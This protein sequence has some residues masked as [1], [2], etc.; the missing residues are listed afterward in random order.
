MSFNKWLR[1]SVLV[2]LLLGFGVAALAQ[3][4]TILG[5]VT[6]PTGAT[7]PNASIA[8]TNVDTG[9]V[10]QI[11][12]NEAGQFVAPGL[13]IGH[14]IVRTEVSGFKPMEQKDIVL[15]VG[16]RLRVDFNLELG[17]AAEQVTV[18]AA[19][20][21][22]QSDSS[23]VS[24]MISGEQV[25]QIATNGRNI[26]LLATL[27]P[28][29]TNAT[30]GDFQLQL[31][32]SADAKY[33]F[34]G[35]RPGH[36]LF[37]IDGG[38][39]YD[40]GGEG[41]LSVMPSLESVAEFRALTSNYSA[42]YG[43]ASGGTTTLVLKSG[44]KQ[45]H[46]AA[47]EFLRNDWLDAGN[48][49]T[50]AAAQQK[51]ELRFNEFGFNIGGPVTFGKLYNKD[52]NK[53]FFFY[54]MEW[55]K[56]VQ[57]TGVIN[58]TVP[59]T[60]WYGGN[61]SG[62]PAI[63]V[64][65]AAQLAPSILDKFKAMG[66]QPGEPFPNNTIPASLLDPNAQVLLKTGIFPAPTSGTQFIKGVT[67]PTN[68]KD[69]TVRIDHR[70]NDKFSIFGHFIAEQIMQGF[71]TSMWS[72]DNVPTVGNNFGNPTYS[73]VVRTIHTISPTLLNEINF[74]YNGNRLN[75][76]PTGLYTQPSGL[77]IPR[78]FSGPN[79]LNR[80]PQINLAGSTGTN[81]DATGWPWNNAADSFQWGDDLS[82]VKGNH[83]LKIGA[84]IMW[85][86]KVQDLNVR[87]Q[88]SYTFN[89]TYTGNDFAD[90]LLG[91]SNSYAEAG[92]QDA[93][94][95]N[96]KS[97]SLYIQDNWRVNK[98]LTLNLGL[99]WDGMP[100]TYE[101]ENRMS[102][103]YPNLYDPTKKALLLPDGTISPNSP[104]L[105]TSPNPILKGVQFYGNGIGIAGQNGVS[106]GLV[107]NYWATFGPRVGF[108]YDLTGNGKTILRGGFGTMYERIQG[109][110]MYNSGANIPFSA[111]VTFTG[112]S[113]SNPG[114]SLQTGQTL[115]APILPASIVGLSKTNYKL[116]VSYQF[117]LGIQQSLGE[118]SVLSLA[119]VGN[120]N[121]H[122]SYRDETNLPAQSALPG[123]INNTVPFNSVVPY[124]GL[125]SINLYE[126]A[127]TSH[128]NSLQASLNSR[129]HKDLSFQASYT[130]SK[131]MDSSVGNGSGGD[132]QS[133][134]NPYD[135][136][137]GIGPAWFN[138]DHVFNANFLYDIPAF[139]HA[140]SR[141]LRTGF[142]GWQISGFIT[143]ET[144]LPLQVDLGG[145]AAYNG[146][147]NWTDN[148][149]RPGGNRPN[150]I[151][152]LNYPRTVN[153]WFNTTPQVTC[154]DGTRSKGPFC[155]PAIGQWG[156]LG[157]NALQG[158]GRH[159]WNLSLFKSFVLSEKRG[160][161]IEFRAE[162]F[163]I[164]N[165]TQFQNVSGTMNNS[166]F[167]QVTSAFDPRVFQLG[168]KAQF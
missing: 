109:N 55:R 154:P 135:R 57:G 8:I 146:L 77:Q 160:S 13:H 18:E 97:Y 2:A 28:G 92:V 72:G 58:Q 33:S 74:N 61:L 50:N 120:Q 124:T 83:Q 166:N 11:S 101:A 66:L 150:V 79:N 45:I 121:R 36:N 104:G 167:G 110:D 95:W 35:L 117:S 21:A 54:N 73:A 60:S 107:D 87:T 143:A 6:D 34:N 76:T 81:Y 98:R 5:T 43:L 139:R 141:A 93:G 105:I 126:N 63:H 103:F 78:L 133:L 137:Y 132:L 67:A 106:N 158:P 70:F 115:V 16:D 53:T 151:G 75:I 85:Y 119:Y 20:I 25:A 31:P 113:L 159:N 38:E 42:E 118:K 138:R 153:N 111:N 62:G 12:S 65:T 134:A 24:H 27:L 3:E 90:F 88:G 80:M 100:H 32:V 130:W 102:N 142:G 128:Y 26:Y 148:N 86:K 15:Q 91:F 22:V 10:L 162:S 157:L 48:Y 136:S 49:F 164:F 144:G 84:S 149:Q 37:I 52:R 82:W 59:L 51:P 68:F 47:W 30:G 122:Q 127:G 168:L 161:K 156:N 123:L 96:H 140:A 89:G 155:A 145:P 7:V 129:L 152:T 112:V 40:R 4:A 69:E 165:H 108:A 29:V 64:P 14:Y 56:Y 39:A 94:H 17:T 44:E 99:R 46:A 163:N 1:L 41:R 9:Q 116:P 125:G 147:P 23:E 131:A 71:T 19:P 114:T